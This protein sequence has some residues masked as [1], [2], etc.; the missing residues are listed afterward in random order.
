[1]TDALLDHLGTGTTTVSRCWRVVRRDGE[2]FGFTDHDLAIEFDGTRFEPDTGMT[3]TAIAQSTGLSIDNSEAIGA[4]R[5]DAISEADLLAGRF[6]GAEVT[7]WLV[8]WANPEE[9]KV[10]FR[11]TVG[12]VTRGAGAFTA[13]LR[14]LAEQLNQPQGRVYQRQCTAVLGDVACGVDLTLEGRSAE[15]ELSD[16]AGGDRFVFPDPVGLAEGAL[17][18]GV[19]RVLDGNASGLIGMIKTDERI[20]SSRV[21]TLFQRIEAELA[22]GDRVAV[23]VGCDKSAATCKARFDNLLNFRGFPH[24]PGEDWLMSYPVSSGSNDGGSLFGGGQ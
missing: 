10:Q 7:A 24:I 13:E 3:A 12:E 2:Q 15:A 22:V 19:L 6:D 21:L 4:L 11:G 5:S 9:R 18:R 16:I 1:M 20:G 14:G 23:S 17:V 8:N